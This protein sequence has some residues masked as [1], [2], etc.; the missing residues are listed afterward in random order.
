ML[1][2][3]HECIPLR[4]WLGHMSLFRANVQIRDESVRTLHITMVLEENALCANHAASLVPPHALEPGY[5]HLVRVVESAAAP[6]PP[7]SCCPFHNTN[8][9][10]WALQRA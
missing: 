8:K 9:G 2:I 6:P 5:S 10:V 3:F 7:C 4:D 1:C